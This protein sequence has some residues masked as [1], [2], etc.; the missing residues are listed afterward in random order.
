MSGNGSQDGELTALIADAGLSMTADELADLLDGINAAPAGHRA[1]AWLALVDRQASPAVAER[2][3]AARAARAARPR[4]ASVA[5][6]DRVAALRADLA[7]RG[8]DGFVVPRADTHQGETVPA[9]DERLAW[10]TGFTGSAGVAV[11]LRDRAAM[12][13]DGRYTL[14]VAAQVDGGIFAFKHLV[15]DPHADWAAEALPAGGRLGH[16]P[17][18]HPVRWIERMRKAVDRVGGTLVPVDDNPVDAIWPD[19]PPPPLAPVVPH[20]IAYTGQ[21]AADK[22]SAVGQSLDRDGV[23]AAVLSAPDSI[24]WLLNVRGADVPH[25]PL[26]LSFAVLRA[27]GQVDLFIDRRKLTPG[28][29][30]H[31]G[32]RVAVQPPD[33]FGDALDA[34]GADGRTVLI[35]DATASG[36]IDARLR[37]AGAQVRSGPDPCA[38]PKARKNEVEIAGSRAA[39]V[40]D[41]GAVARFLAWLA[42]T[43]PG[44]LTEIAAA[45]RLQALRAEDAL[46]RG[47][48]FDTIS[49][50]GPNGAIVHYRVTDETN[51][52]LEPGTLYLVD[53]GGQYLDGTTDITRTVAV[54]APTDEMRRRFTLV[55][56]GHIALATVRFPKGTTGSQ[57]DTLARRFL[58]Q[59]GLDYD[60]GTGHG[61]GSY[62]GVHEGPARISKLPNTVALEPGMIL[63]NEPGYYK[64]DG[65]GIR[66]E[67]LVAVRACAE[68]EGAERPMLDFETLSL[69]PID[70]ALV[71]PGLMTDDDVAWLDAY[72]DRVRE[73]IAPLLDDETAA[74]LAEAT[75]PVGG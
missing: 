59:A 69:A 22:R 8:L 3:R 14:Q 58:W 11:V 4:A 24:A 1:D 2:L 17:R 18:L 23:D 35:D 36:W 9:R 56:K 19:Q 6:A 40:R 20:D 41:G 44:K 61:V 38:L 75:R 46:Y 60:H 25:T 34:L 57:L 33:G 74:W 64:A 54:G 48:G 15:D 13:V 26:P 29:E 62:L 16:D 5:L 28:L 31:L 30:S 42:R 39:H 50:A 47:D 51:R 67:N 37:A 68:I 55:L 71:D 66:V 43:A 21:G 73:V 63:S 65:Y 12:F 49:G 10:L 7:R 27:D 70:L 53:S 45:D 32:N 72:H 52:R